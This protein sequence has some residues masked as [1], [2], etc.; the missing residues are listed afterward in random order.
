MRLWQKLSGVGLLSLLLLCSPAR[1]LAQGGDGIVPVLR[2][3]LLNVAG[4]VD[5]KLGTW[6]SDDTLTDPEG[7]NFIAE[8]ADFIASVVSYIAACL[9]DL[10]GWL[11]F[12]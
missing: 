6:V 1:A 8:L 2:D 4:R 11:N 5:D 7:V 12:L 10:L 3:V 9:G